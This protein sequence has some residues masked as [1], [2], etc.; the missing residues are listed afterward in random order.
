[1]NHNNIGGR[2][3][4]SASHNNSISRLASG[5]NYF[6]QANQSAIFS[7]SGTNNRKNGNNPGNI[8][9]ENKAK[10]KLIIEHTTNETKAALERQN[11][12]DSEEYFHDYNN[13]SLAR[14]VGMMKSFVKER[15]K[16]AFQMQQKFNP[17]QRKLRVQ[18]INNFISGQQVDALFQGEDQQNN[19]SGSQSQNIRSHGRQSSQPSQKEAFSKIRNLNQSSA[20]QIY[21]DNNQSSQATTQAGGSQSQFL[22][23]FKNLRGSAVIQSQT[24]NYFSQQNSSR[25][26]LDFSIPSSNLQSS[27]GLKIMR[28]AQPNIKPALNHQNSRPVSKSRI[29]LNSSL[30]VSSSPTIDDH[31]KGLDRIISLVTGNYSQK[32]RQISPQAH[33]KLND[34]HFRQNNNSSAYSSNNVNP[35]GH[36]KLKSMQ[37]TY[38]NVS[39]QIIP[40]QTQSNDQY[41]QNQANIR[42]TGQ[43]TQLQNYS[44][45]EDFNQMQQNQGLSPTQSLMALSMIQEQQNFQ[46]MQEMIHKIYVN[47]QKINSAVIEIDNVVDS[48]IPTLNEDEVAKLFKVKC[49]DLLIPAYQVQLQRF[50]ELCKKVCI[51]RI[52][53]FPEMGISQNFAACLKNI[54]LDPFND[55][56]A[57]IDLHKNNLGDAGVKLL[58]KAIKK[59]RTVVHLNLASNE[60]CNEGMI[61]IFKGLQRN[62]SLISLNVSTL[63]GMA[64]NRVSQT[65]IAELH[66]LLVK[67][68]F[69][70]FLDVS[71]I[72]LGNQGMMQ[73]CEAFMDENNPCSLLSLKCQISELNQIEVFEKLKQAIIR[74]HL[75]ELDLSSNYLGNKGI[76]Q[77][78]MAL[79]TKNFLEKL[80]VS[81]CKFTFKGAQALFSVLQRNAKM[82]ELVVDRNHLEEHLD[83][84]YNNVTDKGAVIF[85]RALAKNHS[86]QTLN[87]KSNQ[88]QREGGLA[89]KEAIN[90]HG[91]ILRVHLE[92]NAINVRDVEEIN[93]VCKK[94]RESIGK[95]KMPQYQ[96]ELKL[97]VLNNKQKE[98]EETHKQISNAVVSKEQIHEKI[99]Q[100]KENLDQVKA[101][102]DTK[103]EEYQDTSLQIQEFIEQLDEEIKHQEQKAQHRRL[104]LEIQLK[105]QE[106][107]LKDIEQENVQ[108]RDNIKKTQ[109][110]SRIK[111]AVYSDEI[112]KLKE[113]LRIQT[114]KME[115]NQIMA[116]SRQNEVDRHYKLLNQELQQI[117][118]KKD[119]ERQQREEEENK[120]Q[121][122]EEELKQKEHEAKKGGKKSP[123]KSKKR[124]SSG[125]QAAGGA[126]RLT[127]NINLASQIQQQ[128]QLYNEQ[129]QLLNQN[130]T[131]NTSKIVVNQDSQIDQ[132]NQDSKAKS[133]KQSAHKSSKDAKKKYQ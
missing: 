77:I 59:S 133:R 124:K 98:L 108:A 53:S 75:R 107:Q 45:Y 71:S 121:T 86:F 91:S 100:L 123:G 30:N 132:D 122:M 105:R 48:K 35:M 116:T 7:V 76:R 112:L 17:T 15:P 92:S 2:A 8:L 106:Y 85:A 56:I 6:N 63:E 80:N 23:A 26:R 74:S 5:N 90:E 40:N 73:I 103:F 51:N 114:Q 93:K 38:N 11:R 62:Q 19:I 131:N 13:V 68:K 50:Q 36:R 125:G 16:S 54:L 64:R 39:F 99:E 110:E 22:S 18:Q 67:N 94:N 102:K 37:G 65:G 49:E 27:R 66:N 14:K 120:R 28:N 111:T 61:A 32:P 129:I 87:L 58:M 12:R 70:N 117:E 128:Q 43:S 57:R 96:H 89:L 52:V 29:Q 82:K 88:I 25:L 83:L 81:S 126:N 72:G 24:D 55:R 10:L 47:K 97:L 33:I 95:S 31:Q 46:Q 78:A 101:Q 130:N 84:S 79:G 119:I 1:M 21:I 34:S 9:K 104:E 41:Q 60:I 4:G 127:N 113:E 44:G 42:S 3:S 69:I 109:R 20:E 115:V 118:Q